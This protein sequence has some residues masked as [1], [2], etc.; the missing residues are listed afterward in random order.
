MKDW[1]WPARH[2]THTPDKTGFPWEPWLTRD[3]IEILD[4]TIFPK[5]KIFEFGSGG[6]T[7]WYAERCQFVDAIE[8]D[9]EWVRFVMRAIV[10]FKLRNACVFYGQVKHYP[11]GRDDYSP[12]LDFAAELI[13]RDGPKFGPYDLVVVDGRCRVKSVM[14]AAPYVRPGGRIVLDNAERSWYAPVRGVLAGWAVQETSN[15]LWRTDI[16]TKPE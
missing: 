13:G 7:V 1:H 11:E 3:A 12:Y 5:T 16:Y 14:L 2:E 9:P 8:H 6:S 10:H 15:G 4:R